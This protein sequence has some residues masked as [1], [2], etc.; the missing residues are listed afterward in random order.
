MA[1]MMTV[2][3]AVVTPMILMTVVVAVMTVVV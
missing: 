2:V 1:M 3:V